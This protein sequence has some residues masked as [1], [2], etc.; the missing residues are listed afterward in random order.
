MKQDTMIALGLAGVAVYYIMNKS[1]SASP[2]GKTGVASVME[3]VT[4]IFDV[5]GGQY[6]NGWQYYSDG[7]AIDPQGNYYSGGALIWQ[8]PANFI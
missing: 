7:T 3:K 5:G 2:T 8:N 1:A 6:A 4:Q